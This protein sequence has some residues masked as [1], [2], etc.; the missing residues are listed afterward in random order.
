MLKVDS[1][2]EVGQKDGS[3]WVLVCD[4]GDQWLFAI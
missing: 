4:R 2:E 3:G 1:N